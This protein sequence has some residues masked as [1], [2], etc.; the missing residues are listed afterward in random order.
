MCKFLGGHWRTMFQARTAGLDEKNVTLALQT[1]A[2]VYFIPLTIFRIL[3][4]ASGE[5]FWLQKYKKCSAEQFVDCVGDYNQ[6][7]LESVEPVF[8]A[9][10]FVTLALSLLACVICFK[11]SYMANAFMLLECVIRLCEVFVPQAAHY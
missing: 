8:K 9:V 7:L 10:Y 2:A 5:S 6:D 4:V 1:R 11:K 3:A